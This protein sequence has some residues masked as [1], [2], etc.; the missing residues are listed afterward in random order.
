MVNGQWSM[1]NG[2]WLMVNGQWSVVS[3]R[4]P[5]LYYLFPIPHS[6]VSRFYNQGT[7]NQ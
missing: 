6:L 3:G 5:T 2:Q 7:L 1:V 4:S